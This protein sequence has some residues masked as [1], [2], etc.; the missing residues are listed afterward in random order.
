MELVVS[1]EEFDI[2]VQVEIVMVEDGRRC[3]AGMDEIAYFTS[4][5]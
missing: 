2:F 1:A 4:V 5:G 3:G